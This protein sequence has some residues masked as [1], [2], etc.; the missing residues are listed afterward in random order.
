MG[1]R[2][3]MDMRDWMMFVSQSI[4]FDPTAGVEHY[5][6]VP[7]GLTLPMIQPSPPRVTQPRAPP[8]PPSPGLSRQASIRVDPPPLLPSPSL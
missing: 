8:A 5:N 1:L 6:P 7:K 4:V 2:G 3:Q